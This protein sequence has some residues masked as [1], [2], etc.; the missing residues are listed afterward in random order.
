VLFRSD[1][2]MYDEDGEA[3]E[4]EDTFANIWAM[5]QSRVHGDDSASDVSLDST[6]DPAGGDTSYVLPRSL[7][8][9]P[10]ENGDLDDLVLNT[11]LEVRGRHSDGEHFSDRGGVSDSGDTWF[12]DVQDAR[13]SGVSNSN[14]NNG[15]SRRL[16]PDEILAISNVDGNVKS[17]K[18]SS[19]QNDNKDFS[20][21]PSAVTEALNESSPVSSQQKVSSARR[22]AMHRRERRRQPVN[23]SSSTTD[24]E[25]YSGS[26]AASL[27]RMLHS[28]SR[29]DGAT[30]L[31]QLNSRSP[32]SH[33]ATLGHDRLRAAVDVENSAAV[34][35]MVANTVDRVPDHAADHRDSDE[36]A[37]T[38]IQRLALPITEPTRSIQY[39]FSLSSTC[40]FI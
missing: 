9:V 16:S 27:D 39:P 33:G 24:D 12:I 18:T 2:L 10:A 22:L 29:T 19:Q 36:R 38:E 15:S 28:Q 8:D 20:S 4:E 3:Q 37:A 7:N 31:G 5:R 11:E 32:V 17:T 26:A 40:I 34:V 30:S 23:S 13:N 25:V 35:R 6:V 21:S 1:S 14:N